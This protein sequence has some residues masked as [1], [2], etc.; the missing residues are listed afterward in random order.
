MNGVSFIH[1]SFLIT[2]SSTVWFLKRFEEY[3]L[4]PSEIGYFSHS[5]SHKSIVR[6]CPLKEKLVWIVVTLCCS[7]L[8]CNYTMDYR[9]FCFSTEYYDVSA[10]YCAP[11]PNYYNV[12]FVETIF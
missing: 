3:Q 12:S 10:L 1:L 8:F 5:F 7:W 4:D 11:T 2:E 9:V 6:D